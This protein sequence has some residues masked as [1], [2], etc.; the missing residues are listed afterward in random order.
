MYDQSEYTKCADSFIYFRENYVKFTHPV[1]G[2]AAFP[3]YDFQKRYVEHI[4]S[5]RFTITKKFRQG[6]FTT[7]TLIWYLWRFLF[8]LDE[9]SLVLS[10]TDRECIWNSEFV[11][12]IVHQLPEF[13]FPKLDKETDHCLWN[14]E[15]GNRLYFHTPTQCCGRAIHNLFVDESA[16]IQK[17]KFWWDCFWPCVSCD[18]KVI[19]ASSPNGKQGWFYETYT[20]AQKLENNFSIFHSHYSE[21]PDYDNEEWVEKVKSNLGEKLF[22]SEVLAEFI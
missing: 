15:L 1:K 13:L 5:H 19:V 7:T 8:K 10:K 22:R 17:M 4:D 21:H 2:L 9:T 14:N 6:G 18:G 20:T 16:Y 11:R 12:R 3:L